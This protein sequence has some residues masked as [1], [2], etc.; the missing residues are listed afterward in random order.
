MS[1]SP[2]SIDDLLP[3][4]GQ[5]LSDREDTKAE[6]IS[7]SDVLET[8][9]RELADRIESLLQHRRELLMSLLYRIDVKES[10]VVDALRRLPPDEIALR[11]ADLVIERQLQKVR[12]RRKHRDMNP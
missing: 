1:F 12:S 2:S 3:A 7:S 6:L 5:A 8:L 11:L 9:R 10:L 4:I